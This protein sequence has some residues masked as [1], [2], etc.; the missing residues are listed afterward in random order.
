MPNDIQL[1]R[2]RLTSGI[3]NPVSL[4]DEQFQSSL[5]TLPRKVQVEEY[6]DQCLQQLATTS[7]VYELKAEHFILESRFLPADVSSGS[8]PEILIPKEDRDCAGLRRTLKLAIGAQVMLIRNIIFGF[9]VHRARGVCISLF[10]EF[11]PLFTALK[12]LMKAYKCKT[13]EH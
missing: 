12:T 13:R 2:S 9:T 8:V 11:P 4:S 5:R 7:T 6:N 10:W 1:L 3:D